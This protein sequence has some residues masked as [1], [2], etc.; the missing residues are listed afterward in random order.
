MS[1]IA[2]LAERLIKIVCAI[3]CVLTNKR[4]TSGKIKNKTRVFLFFVFS[5]EYVVTSF[6]FEVLFLSVLESSVSCTLSPSSL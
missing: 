6:P 5:K 1:T 3:I 2:K 4:E